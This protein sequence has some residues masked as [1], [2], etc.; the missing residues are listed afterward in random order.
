MIRLQEF[1]RENNYK[2][3]FMP[4][5]SRKIKVYATDKYLKKH[6]KC[7]HERISG[8]L[9]RTSKDIDYLFFTFEV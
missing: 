6:K 5:H 1:K 3:W 9:I 2:Y 7:Q 8:H 4:I